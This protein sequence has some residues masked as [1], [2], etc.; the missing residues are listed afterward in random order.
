MEMTMRV[1][2]KREAK[3]GLDGL[4]LFLFVLDGYAGMH[5]LHLE[6]LVRRLSIEEGG[7]GKVFHPG[8]VEK[9]GQ[10]RGGGERRTEGVSSRTRIESKEGGGVH[11][12]FS[13]LAKSLRGSNQER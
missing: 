8:G 7:V 2:D 6:D 13:Q 11:V 10:G 4:E 5:G 1:D 12:I 9:D 3:V